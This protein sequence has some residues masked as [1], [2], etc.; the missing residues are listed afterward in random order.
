MHAHYISIHACPDLFVCS[1]ACDDSVVYLE[2]LFIDTSKDIFK[3]EDHSIVS[4][5]P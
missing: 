3:P 2:M 4:F 5:L 1:Y